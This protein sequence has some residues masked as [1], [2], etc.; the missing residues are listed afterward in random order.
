[1][2]NKKKLLK[3]YFFWLCT[4][5]SVSCGSIIKEDEHKLGDEKHYADLNGDKKTEHNLDYDHHAFL[6]KEEADKFKALAPEESKAKLGYVRRFCLGV[7][8]S[9]FS[10]FFFFI[11]TLYLYYRI[12]VI[13]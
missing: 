5:L 1:M 10:Y 13:I 12:L 6:G 8:Y 9:I 4:T 3:I 7:L 2:Q 11:A